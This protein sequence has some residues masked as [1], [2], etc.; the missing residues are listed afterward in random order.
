MCLT[1]LTDI[2]SELILLGCIKEGVPIVHSIPLENANATDIENLLK[3]KSG[4]LATYR[5]YRDTYSSDSENKEEELQEKFSDCENKLQQISTTLGEAL[6]QPLYDYL[7]EKGY[8]EEVDEL[9]FVPNGT[10]SMLP[11]HA[12]KIKVGNDGGNYKYLIEDK[13]VS[14]WPTISAL[15]H[16]SKKEKPKPVACY[17][18]LVVDAI[19]D[20]QPHIPNFFIRNKHI[21]S[22]RFDHTTPETFT[23]SAV[24]NALS[25][26]YIS[27][28]YCHGHWNNENPDSS[29]LK[30][31]STE[32]SNNQLLTV[33]DIRQQNMQD[34]RLIFLGACETSMIGVDFLPNE[35]IGLPAAFMEAGL[36]CIVSSQW[37]VDG[38]YALE[39]ADAFFEGLYGSDG[40]SPAKA[41]RSAILKISGIENKENNESD[42]GEMMFWAPFN[43]Y[44]H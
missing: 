38:D 9:L 29:G 33:N 5:D 28:V 3:G 19:E 30:M 32:T 6:I 8:W 36:R 21:V 2:G 31:L 15:V 12:A 27:Y 22:K 18:A 42:Y 14:I 7:H 1:I 44:G 37:M 13:A 35:F 26:H 43:I 16:Y 4:W 11:L 40:E 20:S 39:I 17:N 25:K 41:L 24:L 23:K 34:A 10:L